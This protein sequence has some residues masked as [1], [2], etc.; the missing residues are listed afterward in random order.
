MKAEGKA[1]SW[2]PGS[3]GCAAP[4]KKVFKVKGRRKARKEVRALL[5]KT[6][7]EM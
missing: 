5:K 4:T 7:T 3:I 1:K 6:L 2:V